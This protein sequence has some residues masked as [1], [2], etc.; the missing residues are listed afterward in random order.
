MT[1]A[2]AAAPERKLVDRIVA[3]VNEDCLLYTSRCV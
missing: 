3:V 2:L 1:L